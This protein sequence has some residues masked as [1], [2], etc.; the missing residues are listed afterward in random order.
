MEMVSPHL[1]MT[2]ASIVEHGVTHLPV[3]EAVYLS[4]C[5]TVIKEAF[6]VSTE[7]PSTSTRRAFI[8]VDAV[9]VTVW[10][11]ETTRG[12][13]THIHGVTPNIK[14]CGSSLCWTVM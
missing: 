12:S 13:L 8:F 7:A 3:H 2:I 14:E 9:G 10:C 1:R 4:D 5:N 6:L 11:K